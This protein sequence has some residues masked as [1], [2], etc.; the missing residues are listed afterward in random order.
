MEPMSCGV[1]GDLYALVWDAKSKK[2]Y[3]LNA[4]GRR[5]SAFIGIETTA[6]V[7]YRGDPDE[8]HALEAVDPI[9]PV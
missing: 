3:G 8:V 9:V 2:L 6:L 7:I 4:S 1:G 5:H